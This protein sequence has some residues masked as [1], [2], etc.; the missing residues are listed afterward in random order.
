MASKILFYIVL[1]SIICVGTTVFAAA[2]NYSHIYYYGWYDGVW[3]K[4]NGHLGQPT[5]SNNCA[6]FTT[7]SHYHPGVASNDIYTAFWPDQGPYDS[8]NSAA[9]DV[10]RG[11]IMN[12][13]IKA[14]II[15][16]GEAT[17]PD[18]TRVSLIANRLTF[19]SAF[20]RMA[21]A[22]RDYTN[23]D[24]NTVATDILN[25]KSAVPQAQ[26]YQVLY[27]TWVDQR[28]NYRPV[29]YLYNAVQSCCTANW[30][31]KFAPGQPFR[32]NNN[33][34]VLGMN[35]SAM[36]ISSFGFDGTY[37]YSPA[38]I[39]TYSAFYQPQSVAAWGG[40]WIFSAGVSP[41]YNTERSKADG[42]CKQRSQSGYQSELADARLAQPHFI[43]VVSFNE[44]GEGSQ[45][46]PAKTDATT[47]KSGITSPDKDPFTNFFQ[48]LGYKGT[49][50]NY[51][52]L[53]LDITDN[54]IGPGKWSPQVQ[55]PVQ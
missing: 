25:L 11:N 17:Q 12:A 44:W 29:F 10:H 36:Q 13:G 38:Q 33:F 53:Y 2:N 28:S 34:I 50:S 15:S 22:I 49:S 47:A 26:R 7:Q 14:V 20:L 48:Y 55:F 3:D 52:N 42:N 35:A 27:Q 31:A 30:G 18:L 19:N 1:I 37:N 40:N 23:R 21:F 41:G 6:N 45:I 51:P 43:S 8:G 9:I 32:Q 39:K 16:Y 4:Q 5:L 54:Y 24:E 46:E